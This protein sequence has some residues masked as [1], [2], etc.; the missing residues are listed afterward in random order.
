VLGRETAP[1][2][3]GEMRGDVIERFGLDQRLVRR[4]QQ[5]QARSQ[6]RAEDPDAIVALRCQSRDRAPRVQHRLAADL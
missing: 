5:R 3:I 4:R 6:T 1:D 2:D